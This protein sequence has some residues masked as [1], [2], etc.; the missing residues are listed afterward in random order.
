MRNR[1]FRNRREAGQALA[2]LL[3][4]YA[5]RRD[6]LVL[7]LPRGGVPVGY[8]VARTLHVPLDVFVVRKLG[9]PGEEELAMGALA[10]GHIRVLNEEVVRFLGISDDMINQVAAREQRELERRERLYRNH[11]PAPPVQGH[12][13]ILVDD[14]IATGATMTAALKALQ[15]QRPAR[16]IVAVP[17]ASPSI[18]QELAAKGFEVV[19]LMQPEPFYGVGYWYEQFPQ[20]SDS[21][22]ASLLEQAR[23]EQPATV[24]EYSL[25]R[26]GWQ[27]EPETS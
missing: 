25:N 4:A 21:E 9:V 23:E 1:R 14:G 8:E 27:Q 13:V 6:V 24:K 2:A 11:H 15:Q 26:P 17:V 5:H 7:A 16:I 18:C 22:I 19:C 20:L 3:T 10:P 12:T